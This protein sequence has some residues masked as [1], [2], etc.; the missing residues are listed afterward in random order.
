MREAE[1]G[2]SLT[3]NG[4]DAAS[5]EPRVSFAIMTFN[6][7]TLIGAAIAGALAQDHGNLE[8]VIADDGSTDETYA[9]IVDAVAGYDGPHE[10]RVLERRE[11]LGISRNFQRLVAA[12]RADFI[13][14]SDGDDISEPDRARKLTARWRASGAETAL[15]LS[16]FTPI[17]ARSN[18]VERFDE[19]GPFAVPRIEDLSAGKIRCLGATMAFTKTV[20]ARFPEMDA[21][22][23][24]VDRV[25]PFRVMLL[26]GAID[27][28]DEKLVRYRTLGGVSRNMA[29]SGRD[30]LKSVE[31]DRQR[32]LL[33]DAKQRLADLS[34]SHT[35]DDRS[36]K[37]CIRKIENHRTF[38]AFSDSS[39]LGYEVTALARAR[40][41]R[42]LGNILKNYLKFR[43]LPL[44]DLYYGAAH[45]D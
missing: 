26:G 9:R 42:G 3:P 10:I 7:E 19:G 40:R 18:V 28:V 29:R 44:F 1:P 41:D 38:L 14:Y 32:R 16:S 27:H 6:Q 23:K 30:Y 37:N 33:A 20:F 15:I 4:D 34:A 43:F 21:D 12:C 45:R 8:I 35:V 5:D 2:A 22:V 36:R 17:D 24:H 25:I 31:P 13:V 39:A 11:N